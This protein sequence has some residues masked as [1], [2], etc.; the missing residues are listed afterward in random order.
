MSRHEFMRIYLNEQYKEKQ[1]S[2]KRLK[3][4][5]SAEHNIKCVT[6]YFMTF[7][8]LEKVVRQHFKGERNG[9]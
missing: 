8:I 6:F 5:P 9:K 4:R 1:Y 7:G 3:G 2:N